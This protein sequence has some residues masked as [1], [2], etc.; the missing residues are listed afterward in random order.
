MKLKTRYMLMTGA[1]MAGVRPDAAGHGRLDDH[2]Q[3][4][5]RLPEKPDQRLC[6]ALQG[7]EP[8][9]LEVIWDESSNE[10]VAKLRAMN[11][12]GNITWDLVDV[13]A[14]DAIRLCDEGLAMEY[15]PDEMLAPGDDGTPA[16]EDF[17]DLIVSDCFIPQ[18]VYSTTFGYRTDMVGDTPPTSICD[19]FDLEK[20]PGKRS[21]EKRPINNMEW[22]LICDGVAIGRRLRRAGN[23]RR[24]GSGASPSSTPSRTRL[25]GGLPAPI[26]R[27]FSPMARSSWLDLQ[28]PSLQPDR[29][30]GPACRDALG[31][32]GV[33][34]RRLDHPGRSAGGPPGS[35]DGLRASFATDTQ[36]LADQAKWISYGPARK[37]RRHRWWSACRSRHRYGAAH[38]DRSG[39]REEHLPVQLQWWAD[40]RD[41]LDAKFQA[42]L[43]Q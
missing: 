31:L 20:Y 27:S 29:G 16:S 15:R 38:A 35:R 6:R 40:Y 28:R 34:P 17:G 39:Q 26:R 11:E 7:Y 9:G 18:I 10:A 2:R 1:A 4:G 42:W 13:V 21:L 8:E 19:V 41:D 36:R 12:A 14:A 33:R 3:L 37:P 25:S 43:A 32:P 5:R 24:P 22:A 23:R 30:A